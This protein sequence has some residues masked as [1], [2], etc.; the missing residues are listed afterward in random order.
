[1]FL[2]WCFQ[3]VYQDRIVYQDKIIYQ[4]RVGKRMRVCEHAPYTLILFLSPSLSFCLYLCL[5]LANMQVKA[6]GACV[7]SIMCSGCWCV[8][9]A[10]S[11]HVTEYLQNT[12]HSHWLCLRRKF[13]SLFHSSSLVVV[14]SFAPPP[15]PHWSVCL[16]VGYTLTLFCLLVAVEVPVET[17]VYKDRIREGPVT[18]GE[19]REVTACPGTYARI[20][21]VNVLEY[22]Y[23]RKVL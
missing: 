5:C 2:W 12:S 19:K 23:T 18:Y 17:V 13:A 22:G 3:V 4:D 16:S 1:V 8:C 14:T 11:A 9:A 10:S 7:R 6:D 15:T 20:A 21:Y